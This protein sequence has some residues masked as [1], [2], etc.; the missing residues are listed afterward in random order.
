MVIPKKVAV[1][2]AGIMG[3]AIAWRLARRGVDAVLIDKGQPGHGASS[4]SFAWINAGAKEPI[5]YHNL[6]RRSL[7]MW[8][9]F[10]RCHRG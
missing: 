10:R 3:A 2:G 8:A 7:E 6:N 4:H 5:G 9:S 1:V